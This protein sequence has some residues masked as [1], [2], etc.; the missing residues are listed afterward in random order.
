M[1]V[2]LDV[3]HNPAAA[4]VLAK[5]LSAQNRKVI[6]VASVLEDKD[7][8]SIVSLLKPHINYWHIAEL[9]GISRAAEGQSLLKLLYNSGCEGTLSK[10]IKDAFLSATCQ[11]QDNGQVV[12]FGSFHTVAAVLD[13]ISMEVTGE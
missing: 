1:P 2:I 9:T 6:G 12:V 13:F 5:K 7:W 3:A 8:S 11:A 10:D 4:A